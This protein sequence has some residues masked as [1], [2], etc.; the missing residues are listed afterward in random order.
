MCAVDSRQ[1]GKKSWIAIHA[2]ESKSPYHG[3]IVR[4][5]GGEA[6]QIN[7]EKIRVATRQPF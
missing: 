5:E 2:T 6:R 4:G 7:S 1:V 3:V